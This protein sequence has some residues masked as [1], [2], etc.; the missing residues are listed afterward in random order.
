MG[1]VGHNL[2]PSYH[3]NLTPCQHH[4]LTQI[5]A[6]DDDFADADDSKHVVYG[7][8]P[9][10]GHKGLG[11]GGPSAGIPNSDTQKL[12]WDPYTT[13]ET[14][15]KNKQMKINM[16]TKYSHVVHFLAFPDVR[17]RG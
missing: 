17:L 10:R 4:R 11:S 1:V 9:A 3:H 7:G 14:K 13:L 8:L 5:A 12:T 2:T 6:Y 16:Y 15:P